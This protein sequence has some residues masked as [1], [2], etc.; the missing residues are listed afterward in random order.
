[1]TFE[2]KMAELEAMRARH[3]KELQDS[4]MAMRENP[5]ITRI[6]SRCFTIRFSALKNGEPWT[7]EFHDWKAQAK[8]L[9]E[10]IETKEN[11]LGWL[12]EIVKKGSVYEQ[13]HTHYFAA[14]V[15]EHILQCL[16]IQPAE[17]DDVQ[18][19]RCFRQGQKDRVMGV[20]YLYTGPGYNEGWNDPRGRQP[21]LTKEQMLPVDL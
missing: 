3:I 21:Y 11:V 19:W 1:M 5:E 14:E 10:R 13:G 12:I 17:P 6:S 18:R 9:A 2:E 16:G 4:L 20:D 15:R 7:V 8:W